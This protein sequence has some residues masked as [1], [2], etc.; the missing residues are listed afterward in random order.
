MLSGVWNQIVAFS[1][2]DRFK[3][4]DIVTLSVVV[5][6]KESW[7]QAIDKM[8]ELAQ[9]TV[10]LITARLFQKRLAPCRCHLRCIPVRC[11][12]ILTQ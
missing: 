3:N 7:Q 2:D 4:D 9:A 12:G 6:S 5:D 10:V 11:P 1:K 8:P